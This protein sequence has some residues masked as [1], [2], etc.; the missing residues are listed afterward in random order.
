MEMVLCFIDFKKAF[1]SIH[2]G[3]IMKILKAY[4]IPPNLHQAIESIRVHRHQTRVMTRDGCSEEFDITSGVLQGDTCA[5]FLFIIV[6]D[7]ALRW[8]GGESRLHHKAQEVE[9]QP[10]CDADRLGLRR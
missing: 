7:H 5:P 4:G 2:R 9:L 8:K 1:D 3:V 10:S 6:L